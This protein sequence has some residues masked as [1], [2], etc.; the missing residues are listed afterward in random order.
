MKHSL[1]FIYILVAGFVQES[2]QGAAKP[3]T[4][5]PCSGFLSFVAKKE[6]TVAA[7]NFSPKPLLAA[8]VSIEACFGAMESNCSEGCKWPK[9][10]GLTIRSQ[11]ASPLFFLFYLT[12]T[13]VAVIYVA[14][15]AFSSSSSS[16]LCHLHLTPPQP[17][18]SSSHSMPPPHSAVAALQ[19]DRVSRRH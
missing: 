6:E 3:K 1:T 15:A 4:V 16:S 11:I 2:W 8:T 19:Q 13:H 9:I 10:K 18:L 5:A 14:T 7:C 12:F 17:L